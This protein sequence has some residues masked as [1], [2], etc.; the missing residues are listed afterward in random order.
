[1][2]KRSWFVTA[3]VLLCGLSL[4][5]LSGQYVF[6][7]SLIPDGYDLIYRLVNTA[8]FLL[9]AIY[10]HRSNYT[11][12]SGVFFSFFAASAALNLQV[13][14]A[15]PALGGS[16]VEVLVQRMVLSVTLVAFPL[17]A[18]TLASGGRLHDVYVSWG[19]IR[20][21]LALGVAGFL[22]F[23]LTS[24]PAATYL[25]G[26]QNLSI[27]RALGWMPSVL[28]CV[29]SN[30]VREEILYRG[31]F[32]R[33]YEAL[34]GSTGANVVQAVIFSLSHIVAGRGIIAYTPYTA[35]LVVLTFLLGLAWGRLTQR[36]DSMLGSIIFHAGTDIPVFLGIFSNL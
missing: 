34:L 12:Y 25:F 11:E 15:Y 7:F 32:L 36:T 23:A 35:V 33:K 31:I 30:G 21:G 24:I 3:A 28:V 26:G 17:V 1:M 8:A 18:L 5:S 14:S 10:T 29:L 22:L 2:G 16:P 9:L 20:A 6:P 4:P 13:L 27:E 19:R